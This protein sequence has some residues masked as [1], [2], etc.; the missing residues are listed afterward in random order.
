MN[1][2]R[3]GRA[4]TGFVLVTA[5]LDIMSMGLVIPVLP[6]LIRDLSGSTAKAS[7][8]NGIFV[9]LW[10]GMQFICSPIIGSLS[11]RFGRR[12]VL[13]LSIGGL[14]A[15]F[16]FMAVAP[17]LAW[18]AV[19]RIVSGITSSSF[20]TVYAYAADVT[21][22]EKRARAYGLIGSAFSGGF[23]LGPLLGGLFGEISLRMPFW[24]AAGLCGLAF[25]YGY[26]VVPE[27]LAPEKRTPF[28]W[29]KAN[30]MGAFRLLLSHPELTGLAL[31][32][33]LMHFAHQVFQVVFVLYA[34]DRYG[35]TPFQIGLLL[36]L[37]GVLDMAV[38]GLLV[39]PM[40]RRWGDR[41]VMVIGLFSGAVGMA[42]MGLAATGGMFVVAMIV[43]GFWGLAMPTLLSLMSARVS[44]S[45]Q[46]QLQGAN[47]SVMSLAGI[48]SP[49]AFG[50]IYSLSVGPHPAFPLVG[51]AFLI[52]AVI[53]LG[54]A[55]LGFIVAQQV[56]SGPRQH[57]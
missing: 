40:V 17:T 8:W 22:I 3:A 24:V 7:M 31:V 9:T 6:E 36:A 38:Q 21:P 27:S 25:L 14:A 23:I 34:G 56:R 39:G 52:G 57:G 16:L 13:L 53:L 5:A 12:P 15:D 19:G 32:T 26:F 10:A 51:S 46:G 44:E 30:P 42:L 45:E 18:L 48:L 47:N 54:A 29:A 41:P 50:G 43:T 1:R 33:F 37:A 11:D 49:L 28:S 2:L 20:T 55:V 4:A 35:W